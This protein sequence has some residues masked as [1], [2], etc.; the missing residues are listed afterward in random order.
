MYINRVFEPAR[1][2]NAAQRVIRMTSMSQYSRAYTAHATAQE[3]RAHEGVPPFLWMPHSGR[4]NRPA[5]P[6][7]AA[8]TSIH[9]IRLV[10]VV[11]GELG[12]NNVAVTMPATTIDDNPARPSRLGFTDWGHQDKAPLL[13]AT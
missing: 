8:N 5:A 13:P 2:S 7:P 10:G 6:K 1:F 12:R 11:A 4:K 3:Q 9:P